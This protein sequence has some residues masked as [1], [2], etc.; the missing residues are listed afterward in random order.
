VITKFY[1]Y[2]LSKNNPKTLERYTNKIEKNPHKTLKTFKKLRKIQIKSSKNHKKIL[3]SHF[4]CIKNVSLIRKKIFFLHVCMGTPEGDQKSKFNTSKKDTKIHM[5][6]IRQ[7]L[8][9]QPKN[10]KKLT[11]HQ[12]NQTK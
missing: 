6:S 1:H 7:S 10:N 2:S 9:A 11:K 4:F 12:I 3:F 8:Q 5:G